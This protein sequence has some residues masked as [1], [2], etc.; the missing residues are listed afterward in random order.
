MSKNS[1]ALIGFMGTGKSTI[2]NALTK[3]LGNDYRFIETDQLIIKEVGKLIPKIFATDGES[4]FREYESLICERVSNLK[5]V[6]ISCG[7]GVVLNKT[8]IE[9]LKKNCHI[10]LLKATP[11][12]IYKRILKNGK[13]TRPILDKEDPK[14]E[15]KKIL[16]LRKSYYDDAAEIVIYTSNKKIK[17][18]VR[19]IVIKTKLKT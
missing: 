8:N 1:I 11:E 6:V 14:R 9:N 18:I 3:F 10:V 19:E 2:G 5:K 17:N 16:N 13:E 15:I 12:E 7:G 4:K